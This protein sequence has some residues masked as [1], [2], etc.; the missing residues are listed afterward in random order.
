MMANFGDIVTYKIDSFPPGTGIVI[1]I[2]HYAKKD[3]CICVADA[4]RMGCPVS[5]DWVTSVNGSD[6]RKAIELRRR[7]ITSYGEQFKKE[8]T[9]GQ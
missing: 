4:K 8:A 5:N 6:K 7:Y 1:G 2:M 3:E 9:N